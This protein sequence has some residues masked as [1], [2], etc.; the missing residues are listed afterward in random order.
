MCAAVTVICRVCVTVRL[1]QL[2]LFKSRVY[3]WSIN[4]VANANLVY[5]QT[6]NRE[7]IVTCRVVRVTKWQVLARMIGF[8][9][10]SVTRSPWITLKY[11]QYSAVADLHNLHFTV[12]HAVGFSV[13]T[14]RLLVTDLNTDTITS[15]HYEVFLSTIAL[16]SSFLICTQSSQFALHSRPCTLHCWTLLDSPLTEVIT[17]KSF[18]FY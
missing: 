16:Y 9:S 10:T 13:F 17:Y 14:I 2:L 6:Q 7:N 3:K 5:S 11:R 15:N 4:R 12:A 18:A 8:I 1:L